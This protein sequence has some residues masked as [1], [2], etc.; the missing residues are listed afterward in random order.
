MEQKNSMDKLGGGQDV[1]WETWCVIWVTGAVVK[2]KPEDADKIVGHLKFGTEFKAICEDHQP[3]WL[4]TPKGEYVLRFG[5][6]TAHTFAVRSSV[7]G[8][9]EQYVVN[10]PF[11]KARSYHQMQHPEGSMES[12]KRLDYS[13]GTPLLPGW[14]L[15]VL[16]R[17][18]DDWIRHQAGWSPTKGG[19]ME[20][21]IEKRKK[22][23]PVVGA[24]LKTLY[25]SPPKPNQPRGAHHNDEVKMQESKY[26]QEEGLGPP[27]PPKKRHMV[28][29]YE[30]LDVDPKKVD[31]CVDVK[32]IEKKYR[33]ATLAAAACLIRDLSGDDAKD[34]DFEWNKG[35]L[36]IMASALE[37]SG[38][39][40]LSMLPLI[41]QKISPMP[42]LKSIPKNL[43][44]KGPRKSEERKK[45]KKQ[46]G[47][48]GGFFSFGSR[49]KSKQQPSFGTKGGGGE[50]E[51]DIPDRSTKSK[52][53]ARSSKR[54]A[55][56]EDVSTER[57][58][59][60][61]VR[62]AQ[63]A[64]EKHAEGWKW[65]WGKIGLVAIGG[66]IV[67]AFTAGLAAPLVG[68]GLVA[69]GV[70]SSPP[71]GGAIFFGVA[72]GGYATR[73]IGYKVDRRIANI[74]EFEF[75]PLSPKAM[76]DSEKGSMSIVLG[77]GG[78]H[79]DEQKVD[80]ELKEI[81]GCRFGDNFARGKEVYALKW[82]SHIQA[83]FGNALS[84]M[85]KNKI[86]EY[87][88]SKGIA[89]SALH[90]VAVA[91]ATPLLVMELTDVIDNSYSVALNRAD[92]AAL[93]LADA[94]R[95][96]VQGSRPITIIAYSL[97]A[98]IVFKALEILAEEMSIKGDGGG[99]ENDDAESKQV[100][101]D[102]DGPQTAP[103][104]PPSRQDGAGHEHGEERKENRGSGHK[105]RG[106]GQQ[107][108]GGN[109]PPR[110]YD[111][112]KENPRSM[113]MDVVLMGAAVSAD[114]NRWRKVR[115][116]VAGRLVNVYSP[117]DWLLRVL[118][119]SSEM[120][121]SLAGIQPSYCACLLLQIQNVGGVENIDVSAVV[122]DHF[123]YD[124][125]IMS[126]LEIIKFY[127]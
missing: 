29:G 69:V 65:R 108:N 106:E 58:L 62:A 75:K 16:E 59:R 115:Q 101:Q 15:I 109:K 124:K 103:P 53:G 54:M 96:R 41:K 31:E 122:V 26:Q 5:L 51:E 85:M 114:T 1:E 33:R 27:L 88:I 3:S 67:T 127:P 118:V 64:K 30:F 52:G 36:E 119:R 89:M 46:E 2:E 19:K 40:L 112:G 10:G 42:F 77:V 57:A 117:L 8:K 22:N 90:A 47:G 70:L 17:G 100:D 35:F 123:A 104:P 4:K 44:G 13:K 61:T 102:H 9:A 60:V 18:S 71:S 97:G 12:M 20:A 68:A 7:A 111:H 50:K 116:V 80:E 95:T 43:G 28:H 78:W 94:L 73:M 34:D 74:E 21:G 113:V 55:A 79:I 38:D 25:P 76:P 81:W 105:E 14:T 110:F 99:E 56:G 126:I 92:K 125:E 24:E 32:K 23:M 86:S 83:E 39:E 37:L 120:S 84:S 11:G 45:K 87:A 66:G 91:M 48:G 98:R 6:N 49:E 121:Y 72:V 82:E 93:L 107:G 63:D